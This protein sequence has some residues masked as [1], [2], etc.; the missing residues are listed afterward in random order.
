MVASTELTIW[1]RLLNTGPNAMPR[2]VAE[3]FIGLRIAEADNR[4]IEELAE[5]C[6]LGALSS[7]EL[8]E[9]ESYVFAGN[10]L[11]IMQSRARIALR[12]LNGNGQ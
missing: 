8:K 11:T 12:N 3:Y 1:D 6:Q 10:V 5:R 7:D 9:Y 2:A 4:R